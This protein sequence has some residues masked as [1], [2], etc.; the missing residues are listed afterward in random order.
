MTPAL[1]I[2]QPWL[3][4]VDMYTSRVESWLVEVPTIVL[5]F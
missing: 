1:T 2:T 4:V 3:C 5:G